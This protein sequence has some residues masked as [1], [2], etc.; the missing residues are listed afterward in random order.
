MTGVTGHSKAGK[1]THQGRRGVS[2]VDAQRE[3]AP[4][5]NVATCK[6]SQDATYMTSPCLYQKGT[7]KQGENIS[8][9]SLLALTS[10]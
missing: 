1:A 4:C 7:T 10:F 3:E 2:E 9:E 5:S 8:I 6:I